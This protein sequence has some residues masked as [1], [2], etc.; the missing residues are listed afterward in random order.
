MTPIP[1]EMKMNK[2]RKMIFQLVSGGI[3]GGLAG[4]FGIGLL[5]AE[6]M[7]ADQVIVSGT[8]LVYLLMGVLVGFGLVAPKLGS[9][10]LNVED[11]EE[12]E[13]QRRILSGSTICMVALGAALMAL[14]LAGPGGSIPPLVGFGGLLAALTLLIAISIRD[15]KHYDEMLRELSRDA[16]NLAFSGI[17]GVL[18]IWGSAAWLG[19][20]AAPTPLG[21]IAVIS[22]GFLLSI[23]VATA[24]RGLLRP[25]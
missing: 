5:G 17:G 12:I 24:R 3:V 11:A 9:N 15:W 21:L 4:Y 6:N 14:P 18:L 23:F 22:A 25:R 8:G 19:L 10:I 16:G 7:A 20:A 2:N 13:E 1:S